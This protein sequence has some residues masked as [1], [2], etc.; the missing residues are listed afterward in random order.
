[1]YGNR[2][3]DFSLSTTT[4]GKVKVKLA[5]TEANLTSA[6]VKVLSKQQKPHETMVQKAIRVAMQDDKSFLIELCQEVQSQKNET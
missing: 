6:I 4:S 5:S 3:Q 2:K 1:M